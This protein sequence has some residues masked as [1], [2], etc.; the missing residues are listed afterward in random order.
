MTSSRTVTPSSDEANVEEYDGRKNVVAVID[1]GGDRKVED[2]RQESEK[3]D[4]RLGVDGGTGVFQNGKLSQND[5][6]QVPLV[7]SE[8]DKKE[9]EVLE[10]RNRK[11]SDHPSRGKA[12]WSMKNELEDWLVPMAI[13]QQS[14][15]TSRKRWPWQEVVKLFQDGGS[16]ADEVVGSGVLEGNSVA[17]LE[18]VGKSEFASRCQRKELLSEETDVKATDS[19][20]PSSAFEIEE[21]TS[22]MMQT[23]K[24]GK[25]SGETLELNEKRKKNN[26]DD[27]NEC[28]KYLKDSDIL[29]EF[30][31]LKILAE[32]VKTGESV[33]EMQD[34]YPGF[35]RRDEL[36]HGSSCYEKKSHDCIET[37]LR[38]SSRNRNVVEKE[39]G[40]V[41]SERLYLPKPHSGGED[42]EKQNGS[43]HFDCGEDLN[44]NKNSTSSQRTGRPKE[45]IQPTGG[46]VREGAAF[47]DKGKDIAKKGMKINREGRQK[48]RNATNTNV[49][50]VNDDAQYDRGKTYVYNEHGKHQVSSDARKSL[51]TERANL[52]GSHGNT[53]DDRKKPENIACNAQ[54]CKTSD[55]IWEYFKLSAKTYSQV[56]SREKVAVSPDEGERDSKWENKEEIDVKLDEDS[57]SL[58][59]SDDEN[60]TSVKNEMDKLHPDDVDFSEISSLSSELTQEYDPRSSMT[61]Q[62]GVTDR[63]METDFYYADLDHYPDFD[64]SYFGA[65][66]SEKSSE[67][68]KVKQI[69]EFGP[70][71][72]DAPVSHEACAYS[73]EEED[74]YSYYWNESDRTAAE[75]W[76]NYYGRSIQLWDG[77]QAYYCGEDLKLNKK[78]TSSQRTGRPN[79]RIQPTMGDVTE[80]AVFSDKGKV[81]AKKGMKINR[82]GRQKARNATN[83]NVQDVNNDVKDDRG[84]PYAYNK[85]VKYQVSSDPGKSFTTKRANLQGN[86]GNTNDDKE[87]PEN[88]GCKTSD[89][90]WEYFKLFAKTYSQDVSRE[91]VAVSPDEGERDS[92][93]ENK[94]EI[95]VNLDEDSESLSSSDDENE[96]S[97]KNEMDK[98][99]PDDVDFSEIS[100]LSSE[101]T[102]ESDPRSSMTDQYGVTDR[103]TE[104]DFYYA[105]MDRYPDFDTSYFGAEWSEKSSVKS[106]VKQI[107]EFGRTFVDAPVSHEACAYSDE[108]EDLYSYYWNESDRTAAEGWENY[109]GRS[110]QL[111]DGGQAY[112]DDGLNSPYYYEGCYPDMN[113]R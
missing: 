94:E 30:R 104:T 28:L 96:T 20:V 107:P 62:Y 8:D 38:A 57:E 25:S 46:D 11:W 99:H 61:D 97:V 68:S 50:D 19:D 34:L 86:H 15:E 90:V 87:K 2:Q 26:D 100:S 29:E 43:S 31:N 88:I 37:S 63:H 113:L 22:E 103:H 14:K 110:L 18:N 77:G 106:E 60:E 59:S 21:M 85:N 7:D 95:D 83:T 39:L 111:W 76:E 53:N 44:L 78:S 4:A 98:L 36:D 16:D 112:Y 75:G 70:T 12:I 51:S 91:K 101:L 45:S 72:V 52:Q 102:Q 47:S 92:K 10:D 5:I 80:G 105:N 42:E 40:N 58:S 48:A 54:G 66:W 6:S 55:K 79:E 27:V 23:V 89:K 1:E 109:Y 65:E 9:S 69:P 41:R 33:L 64:T 3:E 82:E 108:E 74:L 17:E 35:P 81:I 24:D 49:Q 73:D 84:K 32:Q 71:F 93:R 56:V 13:V 67:K